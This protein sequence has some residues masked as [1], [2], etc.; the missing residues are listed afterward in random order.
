MKVYAAIVM[1]MVLA[2]CAG[3]PVVPPE[4][5]DKVDWTVSFLQV[6]ASPQSYRGRVIV[7]GGMVLSAKPLKERTRI[8]VLQLPLDGEQEPMGPLTD[9]QGRFLVFHKEFI[10]PATI[11]FGTRLTVVAEVVGSETLKL[12]EIEYVYPTLES[13][14]LT[15][16]PPKVPGM[17]YRPYPYIG[18]YW[19]P[20]WGPPYWGPYY[21]GL[22]PY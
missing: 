13:K 5:K 8:E 7:V 12:D 2:G 3:T 21:W 14:S 18:A 20:Y 15:V 1:S 6:K 10:D 22:P 17:W 9:S 19:G 4:L 11:P 16:W